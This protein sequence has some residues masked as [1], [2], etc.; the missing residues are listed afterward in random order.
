MILNT[1][2]LDVI[3]LFLQEQWESISSIQHS[4]LLNNECWWL[5]KY[6]WYFWLDDRWWY[7]EWESLYES[8]KMWYW[9]KFIRLIVEKYKC[10]ISSYWYYDYISDELCIAELQWRIDILSIEELEEIH[11]IPYV[12]YFLY[13]FNIN[14]DN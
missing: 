6:E 9:T 3:E 8:I 1:Q 14:Y 5:Y 2:E 7:N 4:V 13:M 11:K 12:R 10:D